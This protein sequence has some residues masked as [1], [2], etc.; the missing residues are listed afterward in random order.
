M[1]L[2]LLFPLAQNA[3]VELGFWGAR[4]LEKGELAGRK[5]GERK[6]FQTYSTI[7]ALLN[8]VLKKKTPLDISYRNGVYFIEGNEETPILSILPCPSFPLSNTGI[9][10]GFLRRAR[11]E[12]FGTN[13]DRRGG[14]KQSAGSIGA[15]P[16]KF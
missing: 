16:L 6:S 12:Y 7:E 8:R 4:G 1:D 15:S 13:S 9:C 3:V 2:S 5:N 11:C 14:W 10:G